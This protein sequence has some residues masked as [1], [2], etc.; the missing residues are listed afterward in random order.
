MTAADT[1]DIA[2]STLD[3]ASLGDTDPHINGA[4]THRGKLLTGK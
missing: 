3:G 4:R 1:P 2:R